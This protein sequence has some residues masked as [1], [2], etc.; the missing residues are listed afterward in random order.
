MG[1]LGL[2]SVG[3]LLKFLYRT[4]QRTQVLHPQPVLRRPA[5]ERGARLAVEGE[6]GAGGRRIAVRGRRIEDGG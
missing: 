3:F 6:S 2:N 1:D 4:D 5:R